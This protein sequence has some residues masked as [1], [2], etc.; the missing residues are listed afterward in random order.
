MRKTTR[1]QVASI[2]N[3]AAAR[4]PKN[5]ESSVVDCRRNLVIKLRLTGI[6]GHSCPVRTT[7]KPIS[8]MMPWRILVQLSEYSLERLR[9][10]AE[11]IPY[12]A[13]LNA[14]HVASQQNSAGRGETWRNFLNQ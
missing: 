1:T 11:F 7:P 10:D 9:D 3:G 8:T 14:G 6:V 2:W 4:A 12:R 5:E 13:L